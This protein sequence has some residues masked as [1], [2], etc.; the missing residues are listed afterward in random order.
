LNVAKA[1][2]PLK[3]NTANLPAAATEGFKDQGAL[4]IT[5][6][7]FFTGAHYHWGIA[8]EGAR[9]ECD[10]VPN[11]PFNSTQHLVFIR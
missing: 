5:N 6:F 9:W 2:V 10:D 1:G 11:G 3:T 8:G 4:A 7:P